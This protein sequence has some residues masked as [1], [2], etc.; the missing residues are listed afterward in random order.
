MHNVDG[1]TAMNWL[2]IAWS[3]CAAVNALLAGMQLSLWFKDRH[4]I[5]YL[6]SAIMGLSAA[7]SAFTELGLMQATSAAAYGRLLQWNVLSVY[8]LVVSLVWLV[9]VRLGSARRWLALLVTALWSVQMVPNFLSPTSVVYARIDSLQQH[10]TFWGE[11]FTVA[12][13]EAGPWVLVANIAVVLI[14]L[15]VVD[16]S[17][18]AWRRGAKRRSVLVGGSI[19]VFLMLGGAHA[20]LVDN[21]L[22]ATPYM[23]S[24]AYLAIMLAMS[25]ELV[26]D[27][28]GVAKA[29]RQVAVSEQR[30]RSFLE[31]VQLAVAGIDAHR[32]I[33]YVNPYL[34][35]LSGYA[36]EELL[37]RPASALVA[38]QEA[39]EFERRLDDAA[40]HGPRPH[41]EWTLQTAAGEL[42][43]LRWSA[44]R[45]LSAEG[46]PSGFVGIAE[47]ITE[48][49][50][51]KGELQ[52]AQRE[53]DSLTR[54]STLGELSSALAH[55]LNQ[56]LA[57]ILSNAQAAR[58]YMDGAPSERAELGDILDDIIRDDKRAAEVI[59][60]LRAL[61][62]QGA[63]ARERF[64]V[65]QA[66][67]D[68]SELLRGEFDALQVALHVD[69]APELPLV[70]AGRLEIQLVIRNLLRN[71]LHA[72]RDKAPAERNIAVLTHADGADV[73]V[74]VT[75]SGCGIAEEDLP[76]MFEAF[77][78]TKAQGL[79]MGLAVARRIIEAHGGRIWAENRNAGGATFSFA[80]PAATRNTA[81]A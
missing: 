9:Y 25:Y 71:A 24:F 42:R 35:R 76:R 36:A 64:Q 75:D 57:A 15:Y 21:G 28:V 49:L 22:V 2:T 50:R 29:A 6:L 38:P 56:P 62:G 30:W 81:C 19:V 14:L 17:R 65:E 33:S 59:L 58:R 46:E 45:L 10:T 1:S 32:R 8:T 34:L 74:S 37:G 20:M 52:R 68:A 61:F 7:A 12:R 39:A 4:T 43:K 69:H 47:D 23:V 31:R 13:G 63:T 26:S 67:Q 55:E 44:V 60:R 79:G 18:Q 3:M 27:A 66:I 77:F 54:T 40:A 72:V 73:V 11:A 48:R 53:M 51:V 80:L 16:A 70:E 5:V 41:A 78:T